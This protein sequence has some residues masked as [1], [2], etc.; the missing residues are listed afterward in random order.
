MPYEAPAPGE[1]ANEDEPPTKRLKETPVEK[2]VLGDLDFCAVC[3]RL[4]SNIRCLPEYDYFRVNPRSGELQHIPYSKLCWIPDTQ[5]N[6][7]S[8]IRQRGKRRMTFCEFDV[9]QNGSSA[10][11][12][13]L[14]K[15]A[16]NPTTPFDVICHIVARHTKR[17][18]NIA[19]DE[20]TFYADDFV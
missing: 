9:L 1:M 14:C 13:S 17:N 19:F 2:I 20:L 5:Q 8:V 4:P 16:V 3:D 6:H 12:K 18:C 15:D 10:R 11:I 7:C